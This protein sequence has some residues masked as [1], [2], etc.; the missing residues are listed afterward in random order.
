MKVIFLNKSPLM[1]R[2]FFTA[3]A[4]LTLILQVGCRSVPQHTAPI[5][6][7][8]LPPAS[9]LDSLAITV[10]GQEWRL[11]D[12][13]PFDPHILVDTLDNG[14]RLYVR[15]NARPETR[16][17]LRLVVNAGSVLEDDDQRGLAHFVEHMAFNGTERFK[18]HALIDYMEQHGMRFGADLNAYTSFDETVYM[19]TIPTDTL[20]V[21]DQGI[22][23]LRDWAGSVSF[24]PDEIQKE[25]GVVIEEWRLGR[26]ANARM[27]DKQLPT[28][29]KG[30][31]YAKRLPIG[32]PEIIRTADR[33]VITRFYKDWY[34]PDLMAVIAIGDFDPDTVMALM[35]DEFE[36]LPARTSPRERPQ[37]TVPG[38]PETLIAPAKD[39]E[40][41]Y[42]TVSVIFKRKPSPEG[43][44]R[45]YREDVVEGL[46]HSMF[47]D[48]LGELTQSNDPPFAF[49]SSGEGA[50]VRNAEFYTLQ[51]L[52]REG[53]AARA[54][55]T[56]LTE[57]ERVRRF[58]FNESEL[59]RQKSNI[60]RYYERAYAER[61]KSESSRFAAEYA[62]NYL[63]DEPVPGIAFEYQMVE[64][65]LPTV[66]IDEINSLS[67][68]LITRENRVV[69]LDGPEKM[70]L[71]DSASVM[72]MFH[73]VQDE[74]LTPYEDV[75]TD[76]PLVSHPP[77]A[78]SVVSETHDDSLDV[79]R[80]KLSNGAEVVL[81]PTAFKND[82]ILFRAVSIGGSSIYPDSVYLETSMAPSIIGSSGLG[83]F[84]P[85]QLQKKLSGR[86][87]SVSADISSTREK[88]SGSASGKDLETLF[89]LIY[90]N[91]T[92]ARADSVT[93]ESYKVRMKELVNSSRASPERAFRDT[94]VVTMSQ[95]NP[96]ARPVDE[97][98][99]ENQ[100]LQASLKVFKDRFSDAS[101]FTFYFVGSFT[102]DQIRP[103][104]EEYIA[105]IPDID[106]N[107][108]WRDT[109]ITPPEGIVKKT[110]R[111]GIEPKA[112]VHLEFTGPF[113]W[114]RRNRQMLSALVDVSK[115]KLREVLR[116]D[117][118][119][120]YGVSISGPITFEPRHRYRIVIS[121][122]CDPDRV[123]EL[124]GRTFVQI[125]SLQTF[126]V[127]ESYL[128][129]LRETD[130]RTW[131]E[132]LRENSF[133]LSAL[134][135]TD[136]YG[137]DPMNIL[138]GSKA[139]MAQLSP[140]EI[141]QA[142]RTYFNTENYALFVLL[143]EEQTE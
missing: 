80:W 70:P 51:A 103:L 101:D 25:R 107:E 48:R 62:R 5:T 21:L 102:I 1:K 9:A 113:D 143:P 87:A 23:I 127:D 100:D 141:K 45:S 54:L 15:E 17:E 84:G 19:L 35:H 55:E 46:Y 131:E 44:V 79:Y 22:R 134:M 58:G 63:E 10:D 89:Q 83:D 81:K 117:L 96:R 16:A 125:D 29:L 2:S 39:P 52:V 31:R 47:N 13:L 105:S 69:L 130:S 14:V 64:Q 78:G 67:T 98:A 42:G 120:T 110:V 137:E 115:L 132:S 60:L 140:E 90:L 95:G 75:V 24:E 123:D 74:E 50:F 40:A 66:M 88:L 6:R 49:A 71:P 28:L 112:R 4:V 27:L 136:M 73:E 135:Y 59:A 106:R 128:E 138:R 68:R 26:G 93:F 32:E 122:G 37:F 99:I 3:L 33:D 65:L 11:D 7:S 91:F 133:W 53:G 142:A 97:E 41:P 30:S 104:V 43:S 34:R 18:K 38:H 114:S 126:G 12:R 118:S 111:K 94:I 86:I 20:D 72:A 36:N 129:K 109:G 121:F 124:V 116:E 82:E 57:A 56:L 139:F 85:I 61:D 77:E 76:K 119:G 108:H 8:T 92:G